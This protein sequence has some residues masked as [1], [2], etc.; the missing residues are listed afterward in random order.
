MIATPW[1]DRF[2]DIGD[3][4]T[5]FWQAG[6]AGEAV[7]FIHGLGG[8]VEQWSANVDALSRTH[9]VFCLDMIGCGKTDKPAHDDYSLESLARFLDRF[10][11]S[12]GMET[13]SLVG[14]SMG[15]GVCLRYALDYPS[16]V[17]NLVLV[18]S[19]ALGPRMALVFRILALPFAERI[20]SLL[21]RRQF[22]SYV[23]SMVYDH[24]VVTDEM[25]DFY[26]HNINERDARHAF[27]RTL[28]TN[29]GFCGLRKEVRD[30]V[31]SRLG[32][33]KAPTLVI[34]GRQ[35]KHM[36]VANVHEAMKKIAN[37]RLVFVDKC[38]HNPQFEHH[39]EFN[40]LV[41]AFLS[42]DAPGLSAFAGDARR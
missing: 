29:C 1:P 2:V 6:G 17:R 16:K 23:R 35:D 25:V 13:F 37:A 19:A 7:I 41:T 5:R 3:L 22:A 9:R 15:G 11:V 10:A 21:S 38:A 33:L 12:Q 42:G 30:G 34:W 4:R 40:R 27:I 14:L 20:V 31:I 39:E 8:S 32:Q 24:G 36:P 18:G 28:T 26:Y